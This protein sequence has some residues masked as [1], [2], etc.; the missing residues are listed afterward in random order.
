MTNIE[1]SP[2]VRAWLKETAGEADALWINTESQCAC[3]N[4]HLA[5]G[6]EPTAA[7]DEGERSQAEQLAE[8]DGLRV[9]FSA[10]AL[11]ALAIPES[12]LALD[13]DGEGAHLVAQVPGGC[14][15]R[16]RVFTLEPPR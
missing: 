3:G 9:H 8:F 1:F 7:G 13:D 4:Y 12:R 16:T 14:G 6:S 2:E 10:A 5:V 15:G 11:Q